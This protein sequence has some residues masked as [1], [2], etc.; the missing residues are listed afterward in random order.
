M[1]IMKNI[2]RSMNVVNFGS[3]TKQCVYDFF[4]E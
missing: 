1:D 4:L 3:C 2:H